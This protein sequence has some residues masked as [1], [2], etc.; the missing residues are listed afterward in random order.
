MKKLHFALFFLTAINFSCSKEDDAIVETPIVAFESY[1]YQLWKNLI[2]NNL[3]FK[4]VGT[5]TDVYDYPDYLGNSFTYK[6]EGIGGIEA[7][8]VLIN[9][10]NVLNAVETPDIVLLGIGINDILAGDK[11]I[12]IIGD[13]VKIVKRLQYVNPNVTIFIDQIAPIESSQMPDDIKDKIEIY[14]NLISIFTVRLTSINSSVIAV[15]IYT[16]FLDSY[17]AD[18]VHYN[19]E[20]ALFV[21]NKYRTAI[22]NFSSYNNEINILPLGDSRVVGLKP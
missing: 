13:I 8:E 2:D 14:N 5:K 17:F 20:G 22:E 21:A 7:N 3:D 19:E 1:R 4:F 12:Q 9:L 16:D 15:D 6:H 18:G 10:R 11:P